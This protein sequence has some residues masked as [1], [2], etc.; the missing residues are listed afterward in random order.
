M[1]PVIP[2]EI[3]RWRDVMDTWGSKMLACLNTAAEMAAVGFALP[4]DAFTRRMQYGPHLLAPT[5]SDFAVFHQEG[6]VL[7]GYHYDLNFLTI[8]GK[9]RYPGLYIW[10]RSGRRRAVAVPD[11][12][13]L[14]QAGKQLEYLTAGHVLAGFHEVVRVLLE[15][16]LLCASSF[17]QR[18][19]HQVISAETVDT[20][21]R[22]RQEGKSLWRVSSTLFGHVQS[23]QVLEPLAPFD[24]TVPGAHVRFPPILAGDQVTAELRA[25]D[26]DKSS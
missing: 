18:V 2:P 12:C 10:T 13:L 9:S 20:I 23:D 21:A 5:G 6:T 26:L 11:G 25:I 17:T 1:D 16:S 8:H 3:P 22:R 19:P 24:R 4:P 7:A 14:I 15:C